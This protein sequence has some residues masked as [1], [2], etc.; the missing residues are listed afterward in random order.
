MSWVKNNDWLK[1]DDQKIDWKQ[2]R[3]FLSYYK[4]YIGW[5]AL[6]LS[7]G[8]LS[9]A[10]M[11]FIPRIFT[12][13]QEAFNVRDI[14]SF[15]WALVAYGGL[16]VFQT[17]AMLS[18]RILRVYVST[19]LNK[20]LIINY[21]S[22]LL[23]IGIEDFLL[24]QQRTNLF[25]RVIDATNIT[26]QFSDI[27]LGGI[28]QAIITIITAV[29]IYQVSPTVSIVL[30][31]S[32]VII[33]VTVFYTADLVRRRRAEVLAA[34]YPL[35]GKL[36]E[37]LGAISI[38][39]VLSGSLQITNDVK[40]LIEGRQKAERKEAVVDSF[41]QSLISLLTT[42]SSLTAVSVAF[43]MVLGGQISV[44]QAF[45]LYILV[46][47]YLNSVSEVARSYHSLASISINIR[48]YH[49]VID[50]PNERLDTLELLDEQN[51]LVEVEAEKPRFKEK[52]EVNLRGI[53]SPASVKTLVG[54]G[55][56]NA[57]SSGLGVLEVSNGNG[58]P[59]NFPNGNGNYKK[60]ES[61][62]ITFDNVTFAYRNGPPVIKNLSLE[63]FKN[64]QT[65]LIGKSGGGKSTILRLMLGL[66]TPQE[67]KIIVDGENIADCPNL[68][69]YRKKF[70]VVSQTDVLFEMSIREN[71]LFGLNQSISD[72]EMLEVLRMVDLEEKVLSLDKGL[73]TTY[74]E[75]L[76]SGGQKQRFTI[77]RALV[78]KPKFV[79]MDEPTS[80]LDFENE[81]KILHAID[82][83]TTDRTTVTVAHRLSTIRSA[84]RVLVLEN[85]IIDS[86]GQHD[87]LYET[88]EYYRSLCNYNS[89]I[90]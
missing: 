67:G 61:P 6:I 21:Y 45:A 74:Y 25:Q 75:S 62:I 2:I 66:L 56:L 35:V 81:E 69:A 50:I 89:F 55:G 76:F 48:N 60:K 3:L 57:F 49:E 82:S 16:L 19:Q 65:C 8:I 41:S 30:L 13:M 34:N 84:D 14:S 47:W 90:V 58:K 54:A 64:E 53:S 63:I 83:L 39:K 32:T 12:A 86:S 27:W 31:I 88:N 24:F 40:N 11:A 43:S 52:V 42:V 33:S 18:G 44:A 36:L 80:A 46:G 23:S 79:L 85:G 5:L 26:G 29:I 4:P 9:A 71:L 22:K 72:K 1:S 15:V 51:L 28:Q 73:D 59:Q 77:A 87:E 10:V 78:R 68:N 37:V 20:K 17:I 38:I 70:G 7:L